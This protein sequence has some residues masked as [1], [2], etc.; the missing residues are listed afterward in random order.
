MKNIKV[1]PMNFFKDRHCYSYLHASLLRQE[2]S[3]REIPELMT[4]TM[5]RIHRPETMGC[6]FVLD[7]DQMT[8]DDSRTIRNMLRTNDDGTP[9][10]F[11]REYDLLQYL[12]LCLQHLDDIYAAFV[13]DW[14]ETQ[15][16]V[17]IDEED[18]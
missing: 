9:K 6:V 1:L 2:C 15:L 17:D 14:C 5:A 10:S 4:Q 12:S 18:C 11:I 3:S 13:K 7:W 8:D 16:N